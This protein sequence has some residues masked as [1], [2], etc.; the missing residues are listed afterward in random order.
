V[1]VL[2]KSLAQLAL[3]AVGLCFLL[4]IKVPGRA[5]AATRH[6]HHHHHH[7]HHLVQRRA[8]VRFAKSKLGHPYR[9]GG[10]G[11]WSYDCSGLTQAAYRHAH[12]WIP[13]VAAA[14]QRYGHWRRHRRIGDLL[15]RGWPAHHVGIY[16]GHGWA[17]HAPHTGSTIRYVRASY[18][19]SRRS[20][21]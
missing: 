2:V 16:V 19:T 17:I 3:L 12:K 11:P 18:F 6:H 4:G 20:P 8:A 1:G 7:R 13:R 10:T 5:E 21:W 14:Q 15:F 9:W